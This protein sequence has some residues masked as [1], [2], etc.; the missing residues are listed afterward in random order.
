MMDNRPLIMDLDADWRTVIA[1]GWTDFLTV[2]SCAALCAI[3]ERTRD[4]IDPEG[5]PEVT[6]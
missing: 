6:A 1:P 3:A 4:Q 5:R 2:E